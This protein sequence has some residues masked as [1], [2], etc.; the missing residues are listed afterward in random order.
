M[1]DSTRE[2]GRE[3]ER[4]ANIIHKIEETLGMG[5][6]KHKE[7]EQHKKPEGQHAGDHKEG[8]HGGGGIVGKIKDQIQGGH[9]GSSDDHHDG[10]KKSHDKKK[11]KD[12]KKHGEHGHDKHGDSS[13]SDSD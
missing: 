11:K 7:G 6:D 13:S 10:D 5:G 2:G 4:M 1:Y 9:G 3:R 8:G 12:K